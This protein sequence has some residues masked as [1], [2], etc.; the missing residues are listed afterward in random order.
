[1]TLSITTAATTNPRGSKYQLDN[2]PAAPA[3][4]NKKQ[5]ENLE[6]DLKLN[7]LLLSS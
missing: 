5:T 4:Q 7:H 2:I 3:K 6:K 1:M